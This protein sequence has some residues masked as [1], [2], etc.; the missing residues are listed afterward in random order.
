MGKEDLKIDDMREKWTTIIFHANMT[1][2]PLKGF[3][4]MYVNGELITIMRE[5]L[6][7]EEN[8][9][10]NLAFITVGL[11]DGQKFMENIQLKLFIMTTCLE[12]IVKKNYLN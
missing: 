11:V 1:K 9:L 2:D 10:I 4:K 12:L 8:F 5:E 6:V 7:M 3:V